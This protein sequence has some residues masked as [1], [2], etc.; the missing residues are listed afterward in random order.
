MKRV[1]ALA[2]LLLNFITALSFDDYP[3]STSVNAL[4]YRIRL[5]LKDSTDEISGETEI[6]F[7][8]AADS[9]KGV[10]LDFAGMTVDEVKENSRPAKFTHADN[11][12]MITLEG[13]YRRDDQFTLAIRYH[14][15]P[16]DGLFIKKNKFG[17]RTFF[18]DNWPN[19][20]HHWFPSI[21]HPYDKATVEFLVTAPDRYDVVAN[22][23]LVEIKSLQTGSRLWHWRESITIPVYCMVV[24]AA[25][26][27]II[28]AGSWNHIPVL[29]YLYPK[30]R[31]RG[32]KDYGR[33]VEMLEF[34]SNLVGPYPYE[35]LALVESSTRFGGME[36]SSNIFFDEKA[37]NGSGQLEGTV[38]H[39]IAHQ[40]F[41]DSV[42]EAD[43][44]HLWLSEGFATYFAHLFFERRDGRDRFLALMR[45]DATAAMQFFQSNPRPIHD[46]QIKDLFQLLNANNYQ[47]G[48]W[49][50][51]M[52]RR[53]MGEEKFFA[54]IRDYY[55]QHR[56]GNAM[57][58]DLQRAM[59]LHCGKPL[60]WFF[61]E[62]IYESGYPVY[63]ARW[64]WDEATKELRL[65]IAQKQ[66]GTT[67]RMPLDVEIKLNDKQRREV[68]EVSER[69]QTF[70]FKLDSRPLSIAIDVDEWVLKKID[71]REEK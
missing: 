68:I 58:E 32:I 16:K 54:A 3:R 1:F 34:Y 21:D 46:P 15:A 43:W 40:W 39:E 41:G 37:Y 49:V 45:E 47:K 67:F 44:H 7:A 61:K 36:N 51:H 62:W 12:L 4:H 64:R 25:E 50:L 66:T 38:A 60:D 13:A 2:L 69:E 22:G 11:R 48:G 19:R 71:I 28:N 8:S 30:D 17:D 42:T 63:D 10:T 18:A 26:F 27:S 24:G 35:K 56:D 6:R 29:Y 55:R 20:A 53:V 59:E 14:G 57:T 31:E 65:R 9:I 70:S 23:A 52:L 33:A 5:E